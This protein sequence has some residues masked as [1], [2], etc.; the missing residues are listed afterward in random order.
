MR[1]TDELLHVIR[2]GSDEEAVVAISELK[3]A[4]RIARMASI[5]S[6]IAAIMAR[7]FSHNIGSHVLVDLEEDGL[8]R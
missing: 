4:A 3:E 7:N 1:T 6:A 2:N 8:S 5:K